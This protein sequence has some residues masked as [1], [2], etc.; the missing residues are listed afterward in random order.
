LALFG[1]KY[2]HPF[3]SSIVSRY[4]EHSRFPNKQQAA[5][6]AIVP[7]PV[8]RDF[9]SA[10]FSDAGPAPAHSFEGT[11]SLPATVSSAGKFFKSI[12]GR[13]VRRLNQA[14]RACKGDVTCTQMISGGTTEILVRDHA[15]STVRTLVLE[16]PYFV[17]GHGWN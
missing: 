16:S 9:Q 11:V 13:F 17:Q 7:G 10:P 1:H 6:S 4:Q 3:T 5:M 8:Q 12:S 15:I 2:F 14:V